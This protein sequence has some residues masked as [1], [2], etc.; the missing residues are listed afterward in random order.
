MRRIPTDKPLMAHFQLFLAVVVLSGNAFALTKE[1]P[2]D[3]PNG[4]TIYLQQFFGPTT[5]YRT[6]GPCKN[7]LAEGVWAYGGEVT[8]SGQSGQS[9]AFFSISGRKAGKLSGVSFVIR[10][11]R[12]AI[13]VSEPDLN[14]VHLSEMVGRDGSAAQLENFLAAIDK[15]NSTARKMG[16]QTIDA[17]KA[18]AIARTW[19]MGNDSQF[20]QWIT[21][22]GTTPPWE[23]GLSKSIR[24]PRDTEQSSSTLADDPKT[25]GRGA[26]GG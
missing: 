23:Y 14:D 25:V 3:L 9:G 18:K 6:E 20:S 17:S 16:L 15:A 1:S 10:N 2:I 12:A 5:L 8:L 26:R 4:C 22:P 7:G 24:F 19:K 13:V 21:G 11:S